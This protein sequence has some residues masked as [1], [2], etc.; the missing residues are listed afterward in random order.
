MANWTHPETDNN[1]LPRGCLGVTFDPDMGEDAEDYSTSSGDICLTLQEIRTE[2]A[3]ARAEA[4]D[5]LWRQGRLHIFESR[6]ALLKIAHD[7]GLSETQI[8]RALRA[9]IP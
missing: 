8:Q 2:G 7:H 3:V 4:W 6:H 1:P 9:K 5:R